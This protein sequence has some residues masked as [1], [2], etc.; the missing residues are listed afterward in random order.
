V[1]ERSDDISIGM[2][3]GVREGLRVD[4]LDEASE[5]LAQALKS[6]TVTL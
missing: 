5:V 1:I 4:D 6:R 3:Q 2:A